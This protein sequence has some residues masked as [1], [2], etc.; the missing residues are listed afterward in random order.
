MKV[1]KVAVYGIIVSFILINTGLALSQTTTATTGAGEKAEP[2]TE[3]L[4]GEVVSVDPMTSE[5]K[6]KTLDY[7]NDTEIEVLV[8]VDDKTT[9][10]NIKSAAEIKPKDS[11]S[12]D[13]IVT[14]EGKNLAKNI[15]LE[16][17]E[18]S[19]MPISAGDTAP[20]T[21]VGA[22]IPS[23]TE[24]TPQGKVEDQKPASISTATP[25]E[26]PKADSSKY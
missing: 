18:V 2:E 10:E 26:S 13:Y 3:W 9:Y 11:L 23:D 6:V 4:W 20:T 14:A 7:K 17:A 24:V 21:V 25:D 15:S 22:T 5:I 8:N 12:I 19:D 16:K 1:R